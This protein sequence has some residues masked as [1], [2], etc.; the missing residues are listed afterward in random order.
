MQWIV[1]IKIGKTIKM[2]EFPSEKSQLEFCEE[3][4]K[5]KIEYVRTIKGKEE[6]L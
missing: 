6:D 1:A 3:M 2:Y 5:E 4:K